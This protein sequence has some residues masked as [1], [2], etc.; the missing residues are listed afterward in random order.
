M[1]NHFFMKKVL[2]FKLTLRKMQ[3]IINNACETVYSEKE[4]V[5][6]V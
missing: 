4:L 2:I 1:R 3:N 5:N 6:T